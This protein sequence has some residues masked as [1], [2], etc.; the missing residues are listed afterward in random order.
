[1]PDPV[2]IREQCLAAVA[3]ILAGVAEDEG[4]KFLRNPDFQ[5]SRADAPV[6]VMMDGDER[7]E[8]DETGLVSL[9][10]DVA[11]GLLIGFRNHA[12]VG[13]G[14]SEWRAKVRLA[15]AADPSLG[16][17]ARHVR[18]VEASGVDVP[19]QPG[20]K[21]LAGLVLGFEIETQEAE[22]DPYSQ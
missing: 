14:L 15:M 18:Y 2:S 4:A 9:V 19:D 10:I 5:L 7:A 3:A 21:P 12:E 6:I 11:V 8:D 22:D 20:G 1:M 16:G 17:V 13:P